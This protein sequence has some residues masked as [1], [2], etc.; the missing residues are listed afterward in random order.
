MSKT[1]PFNHRGILLLAFSLA[2]AVGACDGG[3]GSGQVQCG[4]GTGFPVP[5]CNQVPNYQAGFGTAGVDVIN[6][7]CIIGP[8]GGAVFN[9]PNGRYEAAG[10]YNLGSYGHATISLG[11]GGTTQMSDFRDYQISARGGGQFSVMM[12]KL[13]GG[14]GNMFLSMAS[15]S[16]W[17]FDLVPVNAGCSSSMA[18]SPLGTGSYAAQR[19]AP[20]AQSGVWYDQEGRSEPSD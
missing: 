11:W 16:D 4:E 8:Q 12:D 13:S 10:T 9:S 1:E 15:D 3:G 17:M 2:F 5:F 19:E 18:A 20:P 14:D 6:V 7:Q